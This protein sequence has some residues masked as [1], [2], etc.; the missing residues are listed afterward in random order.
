VGYSCPFIM[1]SNMA[2]KCKGK[3]GSKKIPIANKDT[4][5]KYSGEI[6]VKKK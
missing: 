2:G 3:K 4:M 1:E 5:H 6:K